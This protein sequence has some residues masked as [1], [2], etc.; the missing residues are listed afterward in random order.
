MKNSKKFMKAVR[1]V[2]PGQALKM[3]EVPL[4]SVGRRDVLVRVNKEAEIIGVSDHLVRELPPLIEWARQGKL[5]L[6]SLITRTLPLDAEAINQALDRLAEFGDEVRLV[7]V[8]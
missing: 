1:L 7:I 2:R 3:E 6:S 4:P 8:P 5:V